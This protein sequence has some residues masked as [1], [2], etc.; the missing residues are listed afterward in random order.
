MNKNIAVLIAGSP[1]MML[2][3]VDGMILSRLGVPDDRENGCSADV[4]AS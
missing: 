3:E 4:A 2:M 1:T